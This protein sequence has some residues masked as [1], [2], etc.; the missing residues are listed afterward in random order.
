MNTSTEGKSNTQIYELKFF[1]LGFDYFKIIIVNWLLTI[2]TLGI[3]YPWAR[4]KRLRYIYGQTSLNN[5]RFHFSG[6]GWEMFLGLIKVIFFYILLIIVFNILSFY[7]PLTAIL[8]LYLALFAIIPFAIHGALRYR[9]SRTSYRS[10]RFGY[11]GNR[12]ELV[13]KFFIGAFLT[14]ITFGIYGSWLSMNIRRYTHKHIRY[15]DVKFSNNAQGVDFFT[16][17]L[18]GYIFTI[19]TFGIYIFWWESNIFN[20]YYNN[21]KMTKGEKKIT[22][23]G[24]STGG[25]FFELLFVNFLIIVFTLGLGRS[26]A[27]MR[28]QRFICNHIKLEGDININ[29]IYQTEEKYTDALGEDASDFF[30]IESF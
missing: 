26:W 10:I 22:C 27:D 19:L 13:K 2:I 15:G 25:D 23:T 3:Y 5:E 29:E 28:T 7:Y 1:G 4:A 9:M 8:F 12:N 18:L 30:E 21:L 14:L 6:T 11:R 16:I 20:Y 17:N 24:T